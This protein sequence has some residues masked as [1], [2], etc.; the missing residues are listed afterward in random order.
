[1]LFYAALDNHAR[2]PA[3][4]LIL[5]KGHKQAEIS[6]S[7]TIVTKEPKLAPSS[8]MVTLVT[9]TMLA[10][11]SLT[12]STFN[13]YLYAINTCASLL[14]QVYCQLVSPTIP[15]TIVFTLYRRKTTPSTPTLT[16]ISLSPYPLFLS[17][18]SSFSAS[19]NVGLSYA[20]TRPC[21]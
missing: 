16:T 2:P 1:M 14:L 21:Y 17:L 10:M 12:T 3:S 20:Q 18:A 13:S 15:P 6:L 11:A 7:S 8:T 4:P 19:L 5:G 9:L